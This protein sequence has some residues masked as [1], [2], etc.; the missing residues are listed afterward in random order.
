MKCR[1]YVALGLPVLTTNTHSTVEEIAKFNAGIISE[2]NSNS[3]VEGIT[4]IIDNYSAFSAG[5]I[6]MS[7][8]SQNKLDYALKLLI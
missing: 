2:I 3:Y 8:N 4:M 5:A 1:E 7:K 6:E